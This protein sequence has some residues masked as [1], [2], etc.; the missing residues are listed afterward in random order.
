MVGPPTVAQKGCIGAKLGKIVSEKT[1][2][3]WTKSAN[4]G[5]YKVRNW[6]INLAFKRC[7]IGQRPDCPYIA[8]FKHI[9]CQNVELL[10]I[11]YDMGRR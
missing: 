5:T 3:Y 10:P 6:A 2:Q 1:V 7:E 4:L 11:K 8:H 9:D